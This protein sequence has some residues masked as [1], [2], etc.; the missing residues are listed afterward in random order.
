M[1]GRKLILINLK[2]TAPSGDV[3]FFSSFPEAARE[4]GFSEYGVRKAYYSKRNRIGEYKLEWLEPILKEEKE[5][6]KEEPKRKRKPKLKTKTDKIKE[7][8]SNQLLYL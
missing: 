6:E 8:K 2:K 3:E 4:M 5:E 7:K 1:A